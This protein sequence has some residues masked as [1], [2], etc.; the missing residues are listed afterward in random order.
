MDVHQNFTVFC[1]FDPAAPRE[2]QY[3]T[4]TRPTT[5]EGL[6][7]VLKPLGG[8]CRV[9]FEVGTQ[10]HWIADI[11][12]P[13][14]QEVQVANPSRVPWLFRD[15]RKSDRLDARKLVTLLFLNQL[16]TVHLPRAEVAA[17]RALI[18][19]RRSLI[20]RRT[21]LKNQIRTI[22]RTFGLRCPHKSCWTQLGRA[23]L[24][25]Q[26]FDAVRNVMMR[27]LELDLDALDDRIEQIEMQLDA[28]AARQPEVA[29]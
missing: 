28:I 17:W 11:V 2:D 26:V 27:G 13:L 6:E 9:A 22:L 15:G 24:A 5:V 12:R 14:A 20:K 18:N 3:Q 25:V 29:L 4:V 10:A 21:I 23:W 8:Q 19:H 16:P 1:L 7:S